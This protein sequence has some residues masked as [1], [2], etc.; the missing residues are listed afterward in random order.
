MKKI[1][2]DGKLNLNK[3]TVSKLNDR[4]MKQVKGGAQSAIVCYTDNLLSL[5]DKCSVDVDIC[6]PHVT[7]GMFC[8]DAPPR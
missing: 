6:G 4:Q 2:I 3:Q 7:R 5:G 1:K 8:D